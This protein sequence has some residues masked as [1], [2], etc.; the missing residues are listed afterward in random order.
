[1]IKNYITNENM[2][3]SMKARESAPGLWIPSKEA[4]IIFKKIPQAYIDVITDRFEDVCLIGCIN[5]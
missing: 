5:L 1:M 4:A 3:E 2:S